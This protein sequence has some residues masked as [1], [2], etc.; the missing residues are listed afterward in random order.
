MLKMFQ[1]KSTYQKL[2]VSIHVDIEKKDVSGTIT[3]DR[4]IVR[5]FDVADAPFHEVSTPEKAEA[6][7]RRPIGERGSMVE[8]LEWQARTGQLQPQMRQAA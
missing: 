5:L 1:C 3:Y 7:L 2:V 6:W 8:T 4:R